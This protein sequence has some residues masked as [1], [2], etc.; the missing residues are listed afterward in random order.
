MA[1]VVPYYFV[2]FQIPALDLLVFAAGE[3]VWVSRR[4]C[5]APYSRDMAS[6][7]EAEGAR[8]EVPDLDSS[9]AS[10]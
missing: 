10:A 8:C 5:K 4:D 1:V 3:E 6:E 2:G 9:V 7:C